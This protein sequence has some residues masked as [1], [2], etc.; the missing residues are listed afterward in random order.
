MTK[1]FRQLVSTLFLLLF[2]WQVAYL[3]GSYQFQNDSLSAQTAYFLE[4]LQ[5]EDDLTFDQ[6]NDGST[7]SDFQEISEEE[8]ELNYN[9]NYAFLINK[10]NLKV[11]L[12]KFPP[13]HFKQ[14]PIPPPE[15][16]I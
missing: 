7:N 2:I 5:E 14:S 4:E 8:T 11:L 3:C 1:R 10:I 9:P 12:L 15:V 13:L 6:F 16:I